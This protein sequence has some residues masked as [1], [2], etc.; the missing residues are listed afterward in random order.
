[1]QQK[2]KEAIREAADGKLVRFEATHI[3]PD[4][5]THFIDFSIKPIVDTEGRV[6]QLI[7]EGRDITERKRAE[8][9][10]RIYKDQL[11]ETVQERT[12]ELSDARNAA[13]SANRSKSAFLA[14]MSH[15]L[16]TPLNA[17]LGFS[18]MMR[19][20]INLSKKQ[21]ESLD[22][23]NRSGENLLKLINNVLD[24]SKMESGRVTLAESQ[25]DLWLL[26]KEMN[27][28]MDA[29]AAAK[30]LN[31]SVQQPEDLPE[32]IIADEG[33][34]RQILINL[35][36]NAIK[37]TAKGSVI[38]R[39]R[40]VA[41]E[42]SGKMRLRFE[43]CDTGPGIPE[44]ERERIFLPFVQ[45]E[46]RPFTAVGTGLGLTI[47]RENA[48]LMGGKI[49]ITD[50]AGFG[51][52]F[53]LEI[54]VSE[55]S[56]IDNPSK[57]SSH[58]VIGKATGQPR[59]RLLIAEDQEEN[60]KLLH[61]MLEPYDFDLREAF[62]GQEAVALSN[63]WHPDLIWMDMR[64][65][66]MDGLEATRRIRASAGGDK[67]KIIAVTAHALNEEQE[68]IMKAGCDDVIPKPYK[69]SDLTDMLTKHLGVN[70][71]F[72]EKSVTIAA[73]KMVPEDFVSLPDDLMNQL[74]HALHRLEV[75]KVNETIE[76][77]R[78]YNAALA[79]KLEYTAGT[80]QYRQILEILLS[81][82][83]NITP[84]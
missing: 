21:S 36:G 55:I 61:M 19:N 34:L 57:E 43:V 51:S 4:D 63:E 49:G 14:S 9:E 70:F 29:P 23:I 18:S 26:L 42:K 48:E 52:V 74:E 25:M 78:A 7:P 12:K 39:S 5:E 35:T 54:P 37:Y 16:R 27:S 47:S 64:M 84:E 33:K 67:I 45:L 3:S 13:E 77:I 46:D 59:H 31:F 72:Q 58:K 15:E 2:L 32:Y 65:P 71:I 60:R 28:L 76:K 50:E 56:D 40:I 30:G 6:V 38:L 68:K 20:D 75:Q 22:I 66:V 11:E 80:Y 10:L 83:S 69:A 8:E 62:D 1:M 53:F 81:F 82:R 44:K 41:R 24:I 79:D 73:A 17:I